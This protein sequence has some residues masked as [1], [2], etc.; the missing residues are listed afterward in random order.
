MSALQ[1]GSENLSLLGGGVHR[2]KALRQ[3][4]GSLTF[5]LLSNQVAI[6][7]PQKLGLQDL[8][9]GSLGKGPGVVF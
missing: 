8:G 1:S 9:E 2:L 7:L 4:L 3:S 5:Q 6:S